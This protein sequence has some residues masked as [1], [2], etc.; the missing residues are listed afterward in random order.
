MAMPT[1]K[2]NTPSG[3]RSPARGLVF[4]IEQMRRVDA[5][6]IEELRIPGLLL[7]EHAAIGLRDQVLRMADALAPVVILVGPGNNAGDGLA[8]ARLL[9]VDH[10]RRS[11]ACVLLGGDDLKG[12]AGTNLRTLRRLT[13]RSSGVLTFRDEPPH[14]LKQPGL[15]IDAMFGS[16]L[17]RPLEGRFAGAV[18]WTAD[19]R[20]AGWTVLAVDVP[21]GLNADT[22]KLVQGEDGNASPTIRADHTVTLGGMKTGLTKSASAEWTGKVSVGDIGMPRWVLERYG[23]P[24]E[25][26]AQG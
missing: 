12:D 9:H 4:S 22:G 18:E 6:A 13:E 7:M 17:S 16:G 3:E 25:Q 11:I 14:D 2:P 8:V 26:H 10:P 15:I 19:H 1:H 20:K 24:I 23:R 21:S 5:F